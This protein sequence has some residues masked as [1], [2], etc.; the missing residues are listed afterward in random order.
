VLE[1]ERRII[2]GP[3][4][5][6]HH[7]NFRVS[8]YVGWQRDG[9]LV[10]RPR[11]QRGNVWQTKDKSFLID[12]LLKGYPIPLV[13]L[14]EEYD[15]ENSTIIRRVVDGQQRL[16][17]VIGYV[18]AQ[19]LSDPE[20]SDYFS[21]VPP[22]PTHRGVALSFRQLT[23]EL[24]QRILNT[25]ISAV[26][27]KTGTSEGVA[28][29][30]Y[31]RLNS[32]GLT[33]GNQELRYARRSGPFSE[34]CYRLARNNQRRWS[35]WQLF[36]EQEIARMREV[37]FTSELV[38]LLLDG[39][40]RTGKKEIDE[41]YASR[42]LTEADAAYAETAFQAVMDTLDRALG[43][44]SKPDPVRPF[45]TRAWFYSVFSLVMYRADLLD[46]AGGKI[47]EDRSVPALSRAHERLVHFDVYEFLVK[48]A[49]LYTQAR[50]S[51][52][53]LA[54]AVSGGA[55]DRGARRQRFEFLRRMLDQD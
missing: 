29:E 30:V 18:D 3:H 51:D 12:S 37:E 41:A 5:D 40:E 20:D 54:R 16:R 33:L 50:Q 11:F 21:Y 24:Q 34:L 25:E 26:V 9:S 43:S 14:Q 39:I 46:R 49:G 35:T 7:F 47:R 45:R 6:A 15:L 13:I 23:V 48:A 53:D 4:V 17:A 8:D 10:L 2:E 19:A 52:T 38:L 44:P 1:V 28:L 22:E 36:R 32:T 27:L 42:E 55:S 31:D